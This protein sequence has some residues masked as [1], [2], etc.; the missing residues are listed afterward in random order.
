M[1]RAA[2]T[3]DAVDVD[4]LVFGA[5]VVD[6]VRDVVD[7]DASRGDV[8]GDQDVDLAVTEGT[9]SLLA[10]ALA[11]V[12]VQRAD[13]EAAGGQ[14]LAQ[15]G[16]GALGTAEDDGAAAT[17]RLEDAGDDL[18]LIHGV[19]AV[20]DLLDRVDGLVLVVGILR[21]DVGRL[22][23]EAAGEGHDGAGH[24][25]GE[26]H[27]VAVLGDTA[28]QRLDVGQ[29]AQVEHLVGLVEDDVLHAGQVQVALTQQVDEAAGRAHDDVGA[30][31]EGLDLGLEGDA[32]VDFDDAGRQVLGGVSQVLGDLLGELAG[33]QNDERL[34]FVRVE[35]VLV[36][37]FVGR[38]DV[39]EDGDAEAEGL[40]GAGL[41]LA[42]DV[43]AVQRGAEGE[44]L[45]REGVRDALVFEGV[46]DRVGDAEVR[47]GLL[48]EVL[49]LAGDVRGGLFDLGGCG[50]DVAEADDACGVFD[51]RGRGG[52]FGGVDVGGGHGCLSARV[53][54][55]L[56]CLPGYSGVG[57][58]A[59]RALSGAGILVRAYVLLIQKCDRSSGC[60]LSV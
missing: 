25:R 54:H 59:D 8:G 28:E 22:D 2:R 33:R 24:G 47:E 19:N 1:P 12:T 18:D 20:D 27:G 51:G 43:V 52:L 41:G 14:V 21:A 29:E 32:A 15:A 36:A 60:R 26:Q 39:F 56:P 3:A 5:L 58:G 11:Q 42:D 37:L 49:A 35:Q 16:G 38:D 9:Q 30:T 44:G 55:D 4:L 57:V 48:V 23:H 53:G 31:L 17:L 40:A 13:G 45:D 50:L 34:R 10:G 7:V 46:D 6:D